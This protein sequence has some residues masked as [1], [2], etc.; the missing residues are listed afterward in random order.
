[1]S[2]L[3][4]L[5]VAGIIALIILVICAPMHSNRISARQRETRGYDDWG[6]G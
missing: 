6:E 4:A 5:L 1:M 2:L 3:I